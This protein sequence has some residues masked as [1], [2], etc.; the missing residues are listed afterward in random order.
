MF[1]NQILIN[2]APMYFTLLIDLYVPSRTDL[3]SDLLLLQ[4]KDTNITNKTYGWHAFNVC[5]PL[6]WHELPLE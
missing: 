2:Q 3:L 5:A 1:V 4:R 6:L